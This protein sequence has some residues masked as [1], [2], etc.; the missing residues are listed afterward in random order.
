MK[1]KTDHYLWREDP[2]RTGS[3]RLL[4]ASWPILWIILP[5]VPGI[6][7]QRHQE[8]TV[9]YRVFF[10]YFERFLREYES[11]FEK[12]YGYLRPV[13]QEVVEKY[14]DCG[15]PMC[16]F[17]RIR[18]PDC[19]EER[20]LMFS[21]K[22]RG[23]CPSCHAK[24]REEWGEWMREEL[25]MAA[26]EMGGNISEGLCSCF[27]SFRGRSLAKTWRFGDF[28]GFVSLFEPLTW[29]VSVWYPHSRMSVG[30]NREKLWEICRKCK[31]EIPILS[32]LPGFIFLNDNWRGKW[33]LKCIPSQHY[34]KGISYLKMEFKILNIQSSL[35][36][37][38]ESIFYHKDYIPTIVSNGLFRLAIFLFFL[39]WT[40][41][42]ETH[43][44]MT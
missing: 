42:K 21:C 1:V 40:T 14:L 12:E 28:G 6:Y 5:A 33:E 24:R 30:G 2:R 22:T 17:A 44:T 26:E 25:L 34:R 31:K 23:F 27:L 41:S 18:C 19:G 4:S 3:F 11:R 20:L 7:R 16:G 32:I 38:V 8:H 10:Y 9:F 36:K 37:Y 35:G 39:N 15:N 13:I 29:P 43:L